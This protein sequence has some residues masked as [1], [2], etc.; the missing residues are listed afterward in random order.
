ME[1]LVSIVMPTYNAEPF[2]GD[3]IRSV[4]AQEHTNWELHVVN[5]ASTDRTLDVIRSFSDPRIIVHDQPR[6]G[7]I[8]S[9]RNR[10][11]DLLRGEFLVTFDSDDI[12]PPKSISSRIAVFAK[13]P[14]LDILDGRVVVYD[15]DLENVQRTFEPRF[16]GPPLSELLALQGRCF[17][18][19]SWMIRWS[20]DIPLR[21]NTAITH[22]EDLLFYIGYAKGRTYGHVTNDVLYYRVTGYSAMS[23]FDGLER[24]YRYIAKWLKE[25]PGYATRKEASL[26]NRRRKSIMFKT[27][28]KA[29]EPLNALRSLLDI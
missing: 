28:L 12:L 5:D 14:D 10:A 1:P 24:S 22:A 13:R 8:S 21:F 9:A 26:F 19:P 27:W 6:N 17:F 11:M 20:K 7:G 16:E 15:R 18:G 2:I 23:R 3:A 29:K 25:H 4:L